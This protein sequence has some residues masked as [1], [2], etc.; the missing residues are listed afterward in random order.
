VQN[1]IS[2]PINMPQYH[3]FKAAKQ[4][5]AASHWTRRTHLATPSTS[6]PRMLYASRPCTERPAQLIGHKTPSKLLS[7]PTKSRDFD[8]TY[9]GE[10][11]C[12]AALDATGLVDKD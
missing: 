6:V 1:A 8:P 4:G 7:P 5:I 12:E 3:A 10:G 2:T 11:D 9:C